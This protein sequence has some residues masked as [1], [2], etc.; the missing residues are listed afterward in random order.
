MVRG[1]KTLQ[2]QKFGQICHKR[3]SEENSK[4][5]HQN[6]VYLIKKGPLHGARHGNTERQRINHTAHNAA[7]QA[8]HTY[9]CTAKGHKRRE[10]LCVLVLNSQCN[11]GPMNQRGD[12]AEAIKIKERLYEESGEAR[13]RIHSTK[14]VWQKANQP[15]SRSSAGAERF[16]PKT[17]CKWYLSTASSSSSLSWW[18]SSDKWWQTWTWDEH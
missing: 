12:H 4:T 17:G 11:N 2:G 3:R 8:D 5:F 10:H 7:K 9:V 1:E 16:D 14:Q 15:F 13:P 18:Q 6:T